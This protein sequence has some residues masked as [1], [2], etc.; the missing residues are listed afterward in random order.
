MNARV[1]QRVKEKELL[2]HELTTTNNKLMAITP[3]TVCHDLTILTTILYS[4][5]PKSV[6]AEHQSMKHEFK[7]QLDATK[8]GHRQKTVRQQKVIA[9]VL[10]EKKT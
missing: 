10:E 8:I 5:F 3:F 1:V 7:A 6:T 9:A 4:L 2:H